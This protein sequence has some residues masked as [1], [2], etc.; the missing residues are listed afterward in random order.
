VETAKGY[1]T[2]ERETFEAVTRARSDAT[3]ARGVPQVVQA[4]SRLTEAISRFMAVVENYPD[5][6]ANQNFLA[7]QEELAST[8]NKIAFARQAYNDAVLLLNNKIEMFPSSIVAD[9]FA[10]QK[11]VFFE[12]EDLA[13]RAAPKVSFH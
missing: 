3:G 8:E 11:E 5:L 10:F 9:M 4:E 2:H 12:M 6:K 13:Q 1:M 7:V